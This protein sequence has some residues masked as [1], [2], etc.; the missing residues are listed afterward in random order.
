MCTLYLKIIYKSRLRQPPKGLSESHFLLSHR[1]LYGCL[2]RPRPTFR[3]VDIPERTCKVATITLLTPR[4]VG[5]PCG[6]FLMG[7]LPKSKANAARAAKFG[8]GLA[9][10]R[11]A[12]IFSHLG[13]RT[14]RCFPAFVLPLF[15]FLVSL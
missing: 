6:V 2:V 5:P 8:N 10:Y 11:A 13:F 4:T 9:L 3:L 15:F 7:V 1:S 14:G 12:A